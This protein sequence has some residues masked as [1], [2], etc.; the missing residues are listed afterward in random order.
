MDLDLLR[1]VPKADLHVHID[2]SVRTETIIELA[3]AQGVTLPTTDPTALSEIVSVRP[4]CSNLAEFL[5]TFEVFYPL[6][7]IPEALERIAHELVLDEAADGVRY[8]E[9]RFAP[10]LQASPTFPIEEVVRIALRGLR[11]GAAEAGIEFGLILCC[12]RSEPPFSSAETVQAA[13]RYREEGVVGLDLA[14]DEKNHPALPHLEP[15]VT[16]RKASLPVTM[17]AGEMG[18]ASNIQEALFLFGAQRL[19]HA[20]NLVEEP[21]LLDYV[22]GAGIPVEVCLNSNLQTGA[23]PSPEA[24]PLRRFVEA[25][26]AVVLNSDDPAVFRTTLSKEFALAAEICGWEKSEVRQVAARGFDAAFLPDPARGR[27]R[28]RVEREF[29]EHLG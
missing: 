25:G 21:E 7:K 13:L 19:G 4:G 27:L 2:G 15:F 28:E 8:V 9:A 23:V 17:H 14:G 10:V 22:V 6:L 3:R 24:H 12:Y 16:A 5:E 20:V 18:P 11:S 26:V 29:D 1:R